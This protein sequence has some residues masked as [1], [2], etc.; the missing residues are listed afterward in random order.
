MLNPD[1]N[2]MNMSLFAAISLFAIS[3]GVKKLGITFYRFYV[4]PVAVTTHCTPD[5]TPATFP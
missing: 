5:I 1:E 2:E 3:P 4:V